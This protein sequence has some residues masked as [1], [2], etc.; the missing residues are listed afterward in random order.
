MVAGMFYHRVVTK[1]AGA[2]VMLHTCM[3]GVLWRAQQSCVHR[4]GHAVP[5]S[6]IDFTWLPDEP[7]PVHEAE[8]PNVPPAPTLH[9]PEDRACL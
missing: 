6:N 9:P 2:I 7:Q 5:Y 1:D 8:L 4:A 3:P